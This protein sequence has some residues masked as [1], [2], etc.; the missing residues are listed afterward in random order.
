MK[1]R[2]WGPTTIWHNIEC[3]AFFSKSLHPTVQ[4]T[5]TV[6]TVTMRN[7]EL[8]T[9]LKQHFYNFITIHILG[10]L[11]SISLET[12]HLTGKANKEEKTTVSI[13]KLFLNLISSFYMKFLIVCT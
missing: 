1:S 10:F 6:P 2:N 13:I 12:Q 9:Y 3:I 11:S 4:C 5:Y 7:R 8:C